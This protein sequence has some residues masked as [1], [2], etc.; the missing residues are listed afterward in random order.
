MRFGVLCNTKGRISFEE[1]EKCAKCLPRP[2][3]R[4]IK[5]ENRPNRLGYY[6]VKEINGCLRKAYFN[7]TQ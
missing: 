5:P 6:G 1:C 3:I 4:A 2:L 7:R